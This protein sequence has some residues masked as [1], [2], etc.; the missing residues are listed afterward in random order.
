[1]LD[2]IGVLRCLGHTKD[3][4]NRPYNKIKG[5]RKIRQHDIEICRLM[6]EL[7]RYCR[8][9]DAADL[10]M[11][12]QCNAVC[13]KSVKYFMDVQKPICIYE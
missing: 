1:V 8:S 7:Y 10:P 12:T 6:A 4:D 5:H 2:Q 11:G 13:F 3:C 9:T